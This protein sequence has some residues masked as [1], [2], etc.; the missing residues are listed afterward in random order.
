[1]LHFAV[2]SEA[3]ISVPFC[4]WMLDGKPDGLAKI[5]SEEV[6][7][8]IVK[9]KHGGSIEKSE[10]TKKRHVQGAERVEIAL[11]LI[12]LRYLLAQSLASADQHIQI[13]KENFYSKE[14]KSGIQTIN[15]K[16]EVFY[17][18]KDA[19]RNQNTLQKERGIDKTYLVADRIP[20]KN[21]NVGLHLVQL[22]E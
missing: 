13:K 11:D 6:R 16:I 10:R 12:S 8:E 7:S 22:R 21:T 14:S 4:K 1:M 17:E 9:K 18:K 19:T 2:A 15:K 5:T 20:Y 3:D